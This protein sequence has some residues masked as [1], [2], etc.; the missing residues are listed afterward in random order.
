M[1]HHVHIATGILKRGQLLLARAALP[2]DAIIC[3]V[4]GFRDQRHDIVQKG[5]LGLD[6]LA[7]VLQMLIVNAGNE[8]RV[9][10]DQNAPLDEHF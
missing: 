2:H 3:A 6:D 4:F 9:D 10:L 1:A 8:D 7:D 5:T